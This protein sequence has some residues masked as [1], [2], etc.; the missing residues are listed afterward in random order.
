MPI[1]RGLTEKILVMGIPR[2]IAIG[3]GT[4]AATFLFALRSFW[5]VPLCILLHWIT[6]EVTKRD[7]NFFACLKRH[8]KQKKFYGV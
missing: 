1:R 7:S 2:E 8:L 3:N 5:V 6:V 4:L